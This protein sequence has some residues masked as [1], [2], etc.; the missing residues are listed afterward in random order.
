MEQGD[1]RIR[2]QIAHI[3]GE[4]VQAPLKTK[5]A[6]RILPLEKDM[7][8]ILNQQK[9]KVGEGPWVFPSTTDGPSPSGGPI[10]RTA[11][12]TCSTGC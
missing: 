12:C 11:S 2:R 1:L 4:V 10:S 3:N 6:Y 7:V 8:D 9:K 5:N